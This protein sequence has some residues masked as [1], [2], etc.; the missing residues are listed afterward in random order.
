MASRELA[1]E[2]GLDGKALGVL[3]Q[4]WRERVVGNRA[5][6]LLTIVPLLLL[7]G[8]AL[9]PPEFRI[10][11]AGQ[12]FY[13]Y[14]L[15]CFGLVP[16]LLFRILR[17]YYQPALPDMFILVAAIWM[18]ISF[19]G[20]YGFERGFASG[21]AFALD[22]VLAFLI[23]RV[24]VRNLT[25][26]RRVLVIAAP[27]FLVFGLLLAAEAILQTPFIRNLAQ[28]V[29]TPL[30]ASE[31]GSAEDLAVFVD[32]R[33]GLLRAT[34]PFT[35]PILAGLFFSS[36]LA[37]YSGARLRSWPLYAGIGAG[38]L[39]IF[40]LSSA[41]FL[42]LIMII[43]LYA[44]DYIQRAFAILN[45]KLFAVFSAIALALLQMVSQGGLISILIRFTLNP[46]T[47]HYRLLI[48]E[49][50]SQSVAKNPLL[51]IGFTPYERLPWMSE[52][53]DAFWLSMAVRHGLITPICLFAANMLAVIMLTK[54]I[55]Q[56]DRGERKTYFG[57]AVALFVMALMGFTV[58]F[59]GAIASWYFVLM[60][61]GVSLA[62]GA[63]NS[64][65]GDY[66]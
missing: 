49:Y 61:I 47:G 38:L 42:S 52:S 41:A 13:S 15:A 29:F 48:W 25:D 33:F 32:T 5:A 56:A 40:S 7:I 58:S 63:K 34:G 12:T 66:K 22:A 18:V 10:T 19:V 45:W 11:V 20:F 54:V 64:A 26:F 57:I 65:S 60:G 37:L 1:V 59:F 35:H 43:G 16:W 24:S 21:A 2:K 31:F 8:S 14:R 4:P 23:A 27:V 28:M 6:A 9:L 51:G 50:G 53:V 44:Y 3:H 55:G 36:L 62:L 39:S 17:G 46:Q 30:S